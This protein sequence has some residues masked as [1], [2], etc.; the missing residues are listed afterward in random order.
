MEQEKKRRLKVL[1]LSALLVDKKKS[2][3]IAYV[4]LFTALNVAVN[5]LGSFPFGFI[6]ISLTTYISVL[7]GIIIG[8]LRGFVACFVGDTLGFI[9]NSAG[10]MWTP[11]VGISTG[12]AALLGGLIMN[13]IPWKFKGAWCIK[14]VLTFVLTFLL[15]T[16]AINTTAGYF[17]WNSGS[18]SYWKFVTIRLSG[19]ICV[20]VLNFVFLF[21]SLP[22]L[23]KIKPLKVK[24]Q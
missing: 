14:L 12:L 20:S 19:Q 17:L 3:R 15:C 4:A 24:I 23:Q 13:G 6:Q 22:I 9:I 21:V 2:S 10:Y 8:P 16:Y 18:W 5:V 11:W 1:L 7:T